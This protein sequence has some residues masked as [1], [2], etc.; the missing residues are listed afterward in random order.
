[1]NVSTWLALFCAVSTVSA[2]LPCRVEV[3][4][5]GCGWPVPLVELRSTHEMRFVTDNAGVAWIDAPEL[6]NRPCWFS[7][8]GHGYGLPKDGFGYSGIRLTPQAGKT[9]KIRVKRMNLARRIG[10]LTGAGLFLEGAYRES[11]CFG[12]DSVQTARFGGERYWFWGDTTLAFYPLGIFHTTGAKRRAT[13]F[14]A[15]PPL[16]PDYQWFR[17]EE[18]AIRGVAPMAGSGPTWISGVVTLP[19]GTGK[20][21]L[22]ASYVKIKPPLEPIV[23]GLCEWDVSIDQF[24]PV[25][26]I[27]RAGKEKCPALPDGHAVFW[28]AENGQEWILFGNPFPQLKCPAAF[29]AWRDP[30][31]WDRIVPPENPLCADGKGRVVPHSGSIQWSRYRKRWITIFTEKFGKPSAFGEVWY[32]EA[33]SPLGPWKNAVKVLSHENY[34]FYNPMIHPDEGGDPL[35]YVLFEGTYTKTF[36]DHA[37]P[38]PRYEYTQMLYRLDFTEIEKGREK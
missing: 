29:D 23:A 35:P 17:T 34:T 24:R 19:D 8:R 16:S 4:E 22:C 10:R 9:L 33:D 21:H 26:E 27:W 15:I 25:Q 12:C 28:R 13:P 11:G 20:E 14:P 1:M 37:V 6:M 18:G 2:A 3:T 5:E 38:T 7:V 32:A 36:A 30:A 31:T